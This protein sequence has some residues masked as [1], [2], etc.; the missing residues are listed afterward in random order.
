MKNNLSAWLAARGHGQRLCLLAG[1]LLL[2][3]AAALAGGN[4]LEERAA[5][6]QARELLAQVDL[7]LVAP[8]EA[9]QPV[10]VSG[11][12]EGAGEEPALQEDPWA[13]YD[14]LGVL[15][16]PDLG[17]RL[18]VLADCTD[19]L[20][21]VSVCRFYQEP[22]GRWIIAGHN[23]RDHFGRLGQLEPGAEVVFLPLSGAEEPYRVTAV[24]SI[25]ASDWEALSAGEWDL[26]LFTCNL[27]MTRRV[28]IRA[29]LTE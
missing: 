25:G 11:P 7:W 2:L 12:A 17:L 28:V 13:G 8:E 3:G 27:D 24:E 10:S 14:L 29:S 18:P 9:S 5:Q 4:L 23:Y 22:E 20:L 26:S 21:K 1:L 19:Q 6:R 16:I 15:S